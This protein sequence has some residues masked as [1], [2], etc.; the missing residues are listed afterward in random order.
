[1]LIAAVCC[2]CCICRCADQ[3]EQGG[4]QE[5]ASKGECEHEHEAK[6]GRRYGKESRSWEGKETT[7]C[8]YRPEE[9]GEEKH[10]PA[11]ECEENRDGARLESCCT[12]ASTDLDDRFCGRSC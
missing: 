4:E 11:T 7:C 12:F 6:G 1:M 9:E 3:E 8:H 2:A 10:A 5:Q